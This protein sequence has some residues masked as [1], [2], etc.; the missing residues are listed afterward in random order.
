MKDESQTIM[1]GK[2]VQTA[3]SVLTSLCCCFFSIETSV[4]ICHNA[5]GDKNVLFVL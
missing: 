2:K 1:F 3:F 4:E 5:G